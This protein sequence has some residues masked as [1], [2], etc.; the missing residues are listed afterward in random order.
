MEKIS[1][2]ENFSIKLNALPQTIQEIDNIWC[3][4]VFVIRNLTLCS[5]NWGNWPGLLLMFWIE[6][7]SFWN[8]A[9]PCMSVR[10]YW[11]FMIQFFQVRAWDHCQEQTMTT[12]V[13]IL[14]LRGQVLSSLWSTVMYAMKTRKLKVQLVSQLEKMHLIQLCLYLQ[15]F[16]EISCFSYIAHLL[17]H[18]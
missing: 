14:C 15:V 5:P 9:C 10:I 6:P 17:V 12:S 4:R 16:P 11:W 8:I 7:A 3:W 2:R 13:F 18:V 1:Y